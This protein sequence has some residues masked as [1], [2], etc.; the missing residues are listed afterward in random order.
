[1][2]IIISSSSRVGA[3]T[4]E[5]SSDDDQMPDAIIVRD[6]IDRRANSVHVVPTGCPV[7][8]CCSS[9]AVAIYTRFA[10]RRLQRLLNADASP[11]L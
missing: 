8:R 1:V 10:W 7:D 6:T 5:Q 4:T 3:M 2:T 11:V 9:A